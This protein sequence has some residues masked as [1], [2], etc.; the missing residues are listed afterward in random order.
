MPALFALGQHEALVAAKAQLL[1]D[2][3]LVALL[4][5]VYI[6]TKPD[7]ARAAFD[8]VRQALKTH[9]G[10]DADLGKTRV[11]NRYRVH[12]SGFRIRSTVWAFG[13]LECIYCR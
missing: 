7:R 2:E 3:L 8:M 10:I 4:D 5:D 12:N 13:Q 6:A 1:P 9:A 11:W